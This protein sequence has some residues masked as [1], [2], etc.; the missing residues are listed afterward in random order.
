MKKIFL[1]TILLAFSNLTYCDIIPEN[2]HSVDK[3]VKII[4]SVDFPDI[5]LIAYTEHPGGGSNAFVIDPTS[6]IEKGYKFNSLQIFAVKKSY[7]TNKNLDSIDWKNDKNVFRA[8]I[9]IDS[10]GGYVDNLSPISSIEEYYKIENV[11]DSSLVLY[12]SKEIIKF[13]NGRPVSIKTY[14]Y[15]S[16]ITNLDKQNS[17]N[18]DSYFFLFDKQ[19][20]VLD[21]LRALFLTILIETFVLFVFFKTKFKIL[22]I[23]NNLLLLTGFLSSFLTLPYLWFVLPMFIQSTLFYVLIGELSVIIIETIIIWGILKINFR[24]AMLVSLTANLISFLMGLL[25]DIIF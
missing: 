13:N 10:Y 7:L 9:E 20:T 15:K 1:L 21:F 16:G 12:K 8:N 6:C 25:L 3:C 5:V 24:N 23:N 14:S 22:K 18:E 19:N 17:T 2:S 4:N 11:R